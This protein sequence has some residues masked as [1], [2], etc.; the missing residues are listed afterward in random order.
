LNTAPSEQALETRPTGV[1]ANITTHVRGEGII[2][3]RNGF[4]CGL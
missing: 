4:T 1:D 3:L 2:K